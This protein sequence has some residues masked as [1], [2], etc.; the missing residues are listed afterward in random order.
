VSWVQPIR[1]PKLHQVHGTVGGV[2]LKG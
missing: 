2:Q 1:G